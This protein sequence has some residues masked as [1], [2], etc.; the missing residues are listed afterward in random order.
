MTYS[1]KNKMRLQK[2]IAHAGYCS[3]RK[4]EE[5]IDQGKVSVNGN[6]IKEQGVQV[7]SQDEVRI[8]GQLIELKTEFVYYLINKP[9]G[10]LSTVEDGFDRQTVVDH[11]K[12]SERVYPVGRLDKETTGA[13]IVTN[14]GEFTHTMTHPSFDLEKQYRVSLDG[15]I[16][17]D[18]INE[19]KEGVTIDGVEYQGV[20]IKNVKKDETKKRTQ[21]TI[22]LYEGKNRQIRKMFEHYKLPVLKLH[23]FALGPL[24]MDDLKIGQYRELKPFEIKKLT[25]AAKGLL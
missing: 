23:R 2:Y 12:T 14:D 22:T 6:V 10:V 5:L 19:L 15:I 20:D 13:L 11:I 18:V 7:G 16:S 9:K 1:N 25:L 3:R 8:H 24:V 4:A 17:Y 21:L